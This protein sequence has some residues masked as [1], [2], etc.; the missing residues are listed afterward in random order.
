MEEQ[1]TDRPQLCEIHCCRTDDHPLQSNV[2]QESGQF[3]MLLLR[4]PRYCYWNKTIWFSLFH[5]VFNQNEAKALL[6]QASALGVPFVVFNLVLLRST[7]F[8]WELKSIP[9]VV[10][11]RASDGRVSQSKRVTCR[12]RRHSLSVGF[13]VTLW[14]ATAGAAVWPVS[15]YSRSHIAIICMYWMMIT[16]IAWSP[17]LSSSS[18]P[19]TIQFIRQTN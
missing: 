15:Q 7:E 5:F 1:E 9:P 10:W 12:S 16:S 14:D 18:S 13:C 3:V 11:C 19:A 4:V 2:E 8:D 6:H 17:F